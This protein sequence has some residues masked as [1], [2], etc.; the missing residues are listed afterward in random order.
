MAKAE[1]EVKAGPDTFSDH[2]KSASLTT[3]TRA[4][5]AVEAGS[6][7]VRATKKGWY[8]RRVRM[9]G[10][11]FEIKSEVAFSKRWMVRS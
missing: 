10:D 4:D 8:G 5:V 11:E 1:V 6:I 9:P 2:L 7:K 3:K